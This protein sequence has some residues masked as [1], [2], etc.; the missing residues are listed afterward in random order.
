VHSFRRYDE[1]YIFVLF[2]C[3]FSILNILSNTGVG[4]GSAKCN[5]ISTTSA[6][7]AV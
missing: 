7:T 3:F 1:I 4:S 2:F 6:N 5:I